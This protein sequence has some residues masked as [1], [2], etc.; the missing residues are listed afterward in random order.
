MVSE[1]VN[2]HC[3]PAVFL[4]ASQLC[5]SVYCNGCRMCATCSHGHLWAALSRDYCLAGLNGT[6]MFYTLRLLLGLAEAG[7]FPGLWYQLTL[8]FSTAE[9]PDSLRE[10]T[11]VDGDS[12]VKGNHSVDV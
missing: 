8:F 11:V 10:L 9:V 6:T 1:S 7:T 3:F 2:L 4:P 5:P 12:A